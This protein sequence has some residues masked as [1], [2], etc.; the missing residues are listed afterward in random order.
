MCFKAWEE[1]TIPTYAK[2]ARYG[3]KL[4]NSASISRSRGVY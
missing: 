1:L 4:G 3:V 2:H